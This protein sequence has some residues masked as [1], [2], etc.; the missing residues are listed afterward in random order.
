MIRYISLKEKVY[1]D[2]QK[3]Y[4]EFNRKLFNNELSDTIEL[5]WDTSKRKVGGQ[6]FET[7]KIL[8]TPFDKYVVP[9]VL[10]DVYDSMLLHEMTH[11]WVRMT[12]GKLKNVHGKEFRNKLKE[13]NS[14][15]E[16]KFIN[17]DKPK[18]LEIPDEYWIKSNTNA[19]RSKNMIG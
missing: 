12:Y 7:D 15:K 8:L 6:A 17:F 1:Y 3:K 11:I 10:E 13:V 16:L 2:I 4:R 14:K 5:G 18:M 19:Q 9:E